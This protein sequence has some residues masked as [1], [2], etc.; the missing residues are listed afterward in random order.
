MEAPRLPPNTWREGSSASGGKYFRPA[1]VKLLGRIGRALAGV[2]MR[3][4]VAR[5]K[6][7]GAFDGWP[8]HGNKITKPFAFVERQD[9]AELLEDRMTALSL[10]DLF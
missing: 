10:L 2:E 7:N 3:C 1:C 5:E 6:L 8:G 4:E 9:F